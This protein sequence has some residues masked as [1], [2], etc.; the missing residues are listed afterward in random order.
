MTEKVSS[1]KR[2]EWFVHILVF[3]V[4]QGIFL[5]FDGYEGWHIFYLNDMGK[6]VVH[7]LTPLTENFRIYESTALNTVT[8]IWGIWLVLH[9]VVCMIKNFRDKREAE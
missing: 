5:I 3:T 1:K 8:V 7:R 2:Y 6:R 4:V 9:G